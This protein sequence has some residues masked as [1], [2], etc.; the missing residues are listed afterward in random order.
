MVAPQ[1]EYDSEDEAM[2][3]VLSTRAVS[4]MPMGIYRREH[5]D[6]GIIVATTAEL[7]AAENATGEEDSLWVDG[8]GLEPQTVVDQPEDGVWDTDSKKP[9]VIKKEPGLDDSMDLDTKSKTPEA[10][11]EEKS[12]TEARPKKILPQDPEDKMIQSDLD[13]LANELGSVTVTED[14]GAKTEGPANKDGRMYLFQFPPLLPPLR[15]TA[16]SQPH[17]KVKAEPEDSNMLDLTDSAPVD[18][19]QEG[20]DQEPDHEKAEDPEDTAGFMSQLLAQGG[21]VG[22]LNVRKSGKVEMDWGGRVLEM[23]PAAGM[24]FL[25]TA[26]IVEEND[27]KPKAGV[28]GGESIGMGKIMGRFVLAPTCGEEEDWDVPAEELRID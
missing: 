16:V 18:L 22:K 1:D 3:A 24:N 25:S 27:E 17:P 6:T 13:L 19:T 2:R 11:T 4:M 20:A 12:A 15:Q 28:V 14:G 26:V 7:E 23:S 10:D 21:M 5:K 8:D 9:I